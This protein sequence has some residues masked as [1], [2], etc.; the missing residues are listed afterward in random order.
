MS[1]DAFSLERFEF[2]AYGR[3]HEEAAAE[4][5][6]LLAHLDLY[7]GSFGQLGT[8]PSSDLAAD[9]VDAHFASRIA[10][11]VAALFADPKFQLS[12]QGFMR[13]I[14]VQQLLALI[15]GASPFGT[16][17]HVIGLLNADRSETGQSFR[18]SPGD[19]LKFSLLYSPDSH[20]ALEPELLWAFNKRLAAGLFT[21]LLSSRLVATRSAHAKR[22]ALL[23]W[24][25]ERLDELTLDELPVD[26]LH[27]VW[28]RCSY[29]TRPDKHR[30]KA[31]I[32][33]LA[34]AK[35]LSIGLTDLESRPAEGRVKPVALCIVESFTSG[36]SV[37]RTHSVSL[38]ALKS[39][40]RVVG[41]SLGGR[42]DETSRKA[43]DEVHLIPPDLSWRDATAR[44]RAIAAEVRPDLVYYVSVG[45]RLETIFLANLRLAPIQM[46]GLGHSA[47]TASSV[48]DYFLVEEDYIGDPQ[49]FT[50]RVVALPRDSS[51][52]RAPTHRVAPPARRSEDPVRIA[53]VAAAMKFNPG[54]LTA[55]RRIG[56]QAKAP[57]KFHFFPGAARGLM[58]IYLQNVVEGFLGERA[59][60][61]P[62]LHYKTYIEQLNQCSMFMSPFPFGNMNGVVDAVLQGLPGVCW[63]GAEVHSRIDEGLFKRLGLPAWLVTRTEDEYVAAGIRLADDVVER[64]RI[65]RELLERDPGRTLFDGNPARFVQAVQ[66]LQ[67]MH[68]RHGDAKLLVPAHSG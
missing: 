30:I 63:S 34:R 57:V 38:E 17:D 52:Y 46:A 26:I 6:K 13:F 60:V 28:M 1:S 9:R 20:I 4:L 8:Q 51:P 15:F 53:V 24:L 54:F 33:R 2:L 62:E 66:W 40:Y 29:A 47:T 21:A 68:G 16:A 22:E 25:P 65:S 11:A 39:S 36:H 3:R 42:S 27:L 41:V 7:T 43:F 44:V 61:F 19:L 14:A 37:Y 31:A 5:F 48:I 49:C 58:K 10:S 55:L 64:E 18:L 45:M 67:R 35:L 50:E 12:E 23:G 56:E 59:V 32:N